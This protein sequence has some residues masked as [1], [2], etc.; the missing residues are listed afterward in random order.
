MMEMLSD[1]SLAQTRKDRVLYQI[2]SANQRIKDVT[3]KLQKVENH[4]Q[5]NKQQPKLQ[6]TRDWT[7]NYAYF[8]KFDDIEELQE[9]K[10]NEEEYLQNLMS[11]P[12]IF[13]HNHDHTEERALFHK[14]E[15]EKLE[16]CENHRSLG[17][18]LF[19][20]GMFNNAA[21]QYKIA[22]SYY[23]YCFPDEEEDQAHLDQVRY[24]CLCN[25]SLCYYKLNLYR[26]AVEAANNAISEN[27]TVSKAFYR[28]AQA[29]RA[30]DEYENARAD[31]A[32]AL[33]ISPNDP[34]ISRELRI[35]NMKRTCSTRSTQIMASNMLNTS[36]HQE[37]EFHS[38]RMIDEDVDLFELSEER[39]DH[40]RKTC[41]FL[42]TDKPLEPITPSGI[43]SKADK[44]YFAIDW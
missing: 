31:L 4:F 32:R 1:P 16:F 34:Y 43:F 19:E 24:A 20:E 9:K 18:Y 8:S 35:L 13:S 38:I 29:Y 21:E 11:R 28:R 15:R 42:T 17:N 36:N 10:R 37:D 3:E 7:K 23:E 40:I 25:I 5:L 12:D 39:Y 22:L 14:P 6:Q 2:E 44:Q 26:E 30:L 33:E 41:V 27:S